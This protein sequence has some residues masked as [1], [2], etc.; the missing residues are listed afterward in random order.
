MRVEGEEIAGF[1]SGCQQQRLTLPLPSTIPLDCG[2]LLVV[3]NCGW[4]DCIDAFAA[5]K[6][7]DSHPGI[8]TGTPT[9]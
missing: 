9:K 5:V 4:P 1:R 2:G 8:A 7:R 6:R 3:R